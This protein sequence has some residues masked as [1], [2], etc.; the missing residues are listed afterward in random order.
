MLFTLT[1][2]R[3]SSAFMDV[4][5]SA[6]AV[7]AILLAALF[8][9]FRP[10]S[11]VAA[12][13]QTN[14]ETPKPLIIPSPGSYV[15]FQVCTKTLPKMAI[16]YRFT[17]DEALV[18]ISVNYHFTRQCNYACGFCFHTAKT[19][20]VESLENAT[21]GIRLLYEAGMKKINFAGGEPF[22]EPVLLGEMVKFCKAISPPASVGENK[23]LAVSIVSNGSKITEKWIQEYGQYV[24]ILAVSC[25]SFD[26]ATNR[27][28]GRGSGKHVRQVFQVRDWCAKAGIKFKI[29]T[30]VTSLNWSEDMNDQLRDLAPARWKVFQCLA[31]D[32]ENAGEGKLRDVQRFLVT[33]QQFDEFIQRHSDRAPVAENNENMAT[34][35]LILDEYMRFLDC[36]RKSK[37]P[38]QSI[39]DEGGVQAALRESGFNSEL[40]IRRGGEY[41][42]HREVV[43]ASLGTV[44]Q[45]PANLDW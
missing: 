2:S 45:P 26:E 20:H 41:A 31:L 23:S 5:V 9:Y 25:D 30:V 11:R 33:S 21:R 17:M 6:F 39:L 36:T 42:Y 29:N 28:I 34:S 15:H 12:A 38:S 37:K 40:F 4:V 7:L 18:P 16:C 8:A 3:T 1:L 43:S 10:A 32:G 19:S 24:D 22:L 44:C 13:P 14:Q 27:D 35:Y